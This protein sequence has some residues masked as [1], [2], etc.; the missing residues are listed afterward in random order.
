MT[1]DPDFYREK[2]FSTYSRI[3]ERLGAHLLI[4][5]SKKI[6]QM[7]GISSLLREHQLVLHIIRDP[8]GVI[9]SR[10]KSRK[11]R[12]RKKKHPKPHIARH[13]NIMLVYDC[14]EWCFRNIKIEAFKKN[15]E[16]VL[17]LIYEDLGSSY[18]QELL[19]FLERQGN[20]DLQKFKE[21]PEDHILFGNVNRRKPVDLPI[22]IDK[23][24]KEGLNSFQKGLVD[25]ITFPVRRY[26]GYKF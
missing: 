19:P 24:W 15:K 26:Y 17:T 3:S 23:S 22:R 16:N 14:L 13:T 2:D 11:R 4:D 5:S 9:Y 1:D 6:S 18:F 8:K 7:E 12:V 25:L 20:L 10:K 21:N